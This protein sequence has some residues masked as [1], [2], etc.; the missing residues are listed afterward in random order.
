MA[1]YSKYENVKVEI[2]DGIGWVIL[3]RP[4]KR[5]AM[6]PDLHWEMDEIVGQVE[7]DPDIKVMV[8]TGAGESWSAGQDLK[9]FFRELDGKPNERRQVS[10]ANERWRRLRLFMFDKPTIAMVNGYCF[11]GAFTQLVSCDFAL[12]AEDAIFGLS[13]V[14]WGILPGG[15]VSKVV[16]D[17]LCYRDALWYA[18]TGEPFDGKQAADMKLI[19]KAV[20]KD[21]LRDETI[22]LAKRLMEINP[23]VLRAT[24]Q[25]VKQVKNMDY[26]QA[27][28]YLAAK[29]AEI[30]VRDKDGG[31]DKGITQFIDEK[32][33]RPGF[34]PYKQG[35]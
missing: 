13:E 1:D 7:G 21:K 31:R 26:F 22:A 27:L 29:G 15:V 32:T 6:S 8:L 14:N 16:V 2:E 9:L 25:A 17:T 34:G 12:A 28:D 11:G 33:Y 24:K 4:E 19:N 30:K 35:S 3:N 5:N 23:E 18:C 20:P 10:F